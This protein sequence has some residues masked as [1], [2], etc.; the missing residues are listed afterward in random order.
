VGRLTGPEDVQLVLESYFPFST[1]ILKQGIFSITEGNQGIE[2][3]RYF[4]GVF[5]SPVCW[6]VLTDRLAIGAGT[7]AHL[8]EI[9]QTMNATARLVSRLPA[10][11]AEATAAAT[12]L[13]FSTDRSLRRSAG[14]NSDGLKQHAQA[15]SIPEESTKFCSPR[16]LTPGTGLL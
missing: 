3:E 8:D 14:W 9:G 4:D 13:E 10:L 15:C 16:R 2:G 6:L 5:D 1:R 12:G 11:R 7:F